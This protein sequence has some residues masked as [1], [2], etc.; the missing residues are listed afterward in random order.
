MINDR[1]NKTRKITE[2]LNSVL[3][4]KIQEIKKRMCD[5]LIKS[6]LIHG[7]EIQKIGKHYRGKVLA[8][9]WTHSRISQK[10]QIGED[11]I[12]RGKDDNKN[13]E[14]GND[15]HEEIRMKQLLYYEHV[16]RMEEDKQ[17]KMIMNWRLM[18]RR[19][20]GYPRGTCVKRVTKVTSLRMLN[21]RE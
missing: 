10:I 16:N 14:K 4:Q 7:S 12:R 8:M 11:Q 20:R 17:P 2:D 13:E 15:Y 5:I 9:E 21:E 1:I 6:T 18:E 19:K 3:C